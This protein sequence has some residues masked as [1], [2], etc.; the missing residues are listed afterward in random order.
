M[1]TQSLEE[2][3]E[4]TIISKNRNDILDELSF[5]N[6][7]ERLICD[8]IIDNLELTAAEGIKNMKV[9]QLPFIGCV[10]INPVKHAL[11]DFSLNFKTARQHMTKSEY[12]DHVR[13]YVNDLQ[14][15]QKE[16]DRQQWIITRTKR[17]NK[18]KYEE[19]YKRLGKSYAELFIQSIIWLKE[20]PYSQE[21]EDKY[22]ELCKND[23]KNKF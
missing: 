2:L 17:K 15:K 5:E 16:K 23:K 11:K 12:K 21:F 19:L 20:V 9:A 18:K 10:R 13:S 14:D 3:E 7:D 6:E 1:N 22:K 8:S 4:F